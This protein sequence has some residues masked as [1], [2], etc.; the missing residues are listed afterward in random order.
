MATD[1]ISLPITAVVAFIATFGAPFW[2]PQVIGSIEQVGA[3]QNC[4]Q[5]ESERVWRVGSQ[6]GLFSLILVEF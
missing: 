2:I 6:S 4:W 3:A 1:L 5:T